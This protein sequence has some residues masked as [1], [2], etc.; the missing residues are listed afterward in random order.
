[1]NALCPP[2]LQL[3]ICCDIQDYSF[4]FLIIF[5]F[6]DQTQQNLQTIPEIEK[7]KLNIISEI[8][9][10]SSIERK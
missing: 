3:D 7:K 9:F 5:N 10:S 1:M 8:E 2:Y 6:N 4:R